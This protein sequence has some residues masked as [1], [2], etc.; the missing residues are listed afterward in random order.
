MIAAPIEADLLA[1]YRKDA[2]EDPHE[3]ALARMDSVAVC[4]LLNQHKPPQLE[5]MEDIENRINVYDDE[6]CVTIA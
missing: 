3:K 4:F 2:A 5:I 1:A 6:P